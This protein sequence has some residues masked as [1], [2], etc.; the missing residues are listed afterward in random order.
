MSLSRKKHKK[1]FTLIELLVVIS[2]I[3][4]LIGILLPALGAAR[5]TAQAISCASNMKQIGTAW[6]AY[7]VESDGVYM[8]HNFQSPWDVRIRPFIMGDTLELPEGEESDLNPLIACPTDEIQRDAF[9]NNKVTLTAE[10]V[11]PRSYVGSGIK[12]TLVLPNFGVM[13]P[14]SNKNKFDRYGNEILDIKDTDVKNPSGTI[15]FYEFHHRANRQLLYGNGASPG[16][17][18]AFPLPSANEEV[19][20]R[21]YVHSNNTMNFTFCDGHVERIDPGTVSQVGER[22]MFSRDASLQD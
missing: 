8:G 19:N 21:M 22:S 11:Y 2:I 20:A 10:Q 3:A 14:P 7:L 13:G 1:A 6:Y 4:L 12:D 17:N 16:W 15:A 5:K 18:H 9:S